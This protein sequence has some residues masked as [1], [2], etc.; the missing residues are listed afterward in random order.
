MSLPKLHLE[1]DRFV[2]EAGRHV[3]LRGVNLGGDCKVPYPDGGTHIPTDFADHRDVSFIGRPFPLSEADEHLGRLQHWGFNCLRLLTTWEACEHAGPGQYDEAYLDYFAE[4]CRKAGEHGLYVFIDFHQD[5]WSRMSG[6]DGAPGWTFEKVGLDFTKFHEAGAAKVMQHCYDYARG[7]GR[8]EDNYPT[9]TWA[10]NYRRPGN[11]IMWTLFFAGTDFAPDLMVEGQNAQDYLQQ[12]YMGA[13]QEVAKRVKDM[14][15]VLGFDTL[16]EPGSG[17]IGQTMSRQ[18]TE[19]TQ[20]YPERVKPGPA[21]SPIDGLLVARG[22]PRSVPF[23]RFDANQKKMTVQGEERANDNRVSIWRD[24]IECPFERAGA[25]RLGANDEAEDINETFFTRKGGEG[26]SLEADYMMP[27]FS[28]VADAIRE[29]NPAWMVFAELDPQRES[30][31]EGFPEGSPDNTVNASHWYDVVTLATKEFHFPTWINPFSGRTIEG[32][33]AIE[34]YYEK[35]LSHTKGTAKTL[36]GGDG[37]PTLI[38]EIGIPYD[39]DNAAAYKAW[40]DG[41]RSEAPWEKHIIALDLMYNVLDQL[42][43][44]STQWNYTASNSNDQMIGDA[45]NQE[46][47]S[48]F[49]RDQQDNAQNKD[50]GGRALKG[51]CRPYIRRAQGEIKNQSFDLAQRKFTAEIS[52]DKQAGPTEIYVPRLHYGSGCDISLTSGKAEFGSDGQV[53]TVKEVDANRL[54]IVIQLSAGA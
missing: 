14:P 11:A 51:F 12:R 43:L 21:W 50:S 41:D 10:Q 13:M 32:A 40:A 37:A 30:T 20:E 28:R 38:G 15:H 29:V 17:W 8:Q 26:V 19:R 2:D 1:G 53:V 33:E 16:N 18:H 24:G 3:I 7:G 48:I 5:V 35:Q 4:V 52:V 9:M 31:H 36:N 47:L 46:D 25:Y 44:S 54:E 39:L 42:L 49:S 27:F 22:V 45:W 23:M 34:D 6:G